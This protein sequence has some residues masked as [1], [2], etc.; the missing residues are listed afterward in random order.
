MGETDVYSYDII[1]ENDEL[2]GTAVHTNH[3]NVKGGK[4]KN[5]IIQQ[6]LSSNTV[7]EER[8]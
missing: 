6:D 7:V 3:A 8:W 5:M 4:V 1:N 2:V